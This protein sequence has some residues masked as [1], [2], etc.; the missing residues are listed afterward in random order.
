MPLADVLPT[1]YFPL[2][3]VVAIHAAHQL[4]R[5]SPFGNI[6]SHQNFPMYGI[7]EGFITKLMV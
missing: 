2:C 5:I 4:V 6:L 1:N 7:H 3:L